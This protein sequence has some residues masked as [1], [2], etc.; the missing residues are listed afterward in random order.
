MTALNKPRLKG[1]DLKRLQNVLARVLGGHFYDEFSLRFPEDGA[2]MYDKIDDATIDATE[3]FAYHVEELLE[4]VFD[5]IV[6]DICYE[7][8]WG[9]TQEQFDELEEGKIL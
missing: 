6:E 8:K 7:H 4:D 5:I 3:A 9:L 1:S 2:G